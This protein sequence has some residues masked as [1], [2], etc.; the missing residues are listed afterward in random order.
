VHISDS[1]INVGD[2]C[3]TIKSGRDAEGR[4]INRPAESY[5]IT[6]C[7]MLRGH[8]GVVIGSEMSGSVKKI[9]ISNC[10]FDG[11]DRGIRLKSTRGRGGVVEDVRVSNVVMK[12]IREE[13]ITLNLYY[14]KAPPEP[15]SERTP[16][17]RR[18]H[19]SGISAEAEQAATLLGLPELP[20]E[21]VSFSDIDIRAKKGFV[22][23][24]TKNIR[25]RGVR[26]DTASGPSISAE[27][28]ENLALFDVGSN[29]PHAGTPVIALVDVKSSYVRGP[30]AGTGADVFLDVRGSSSE[31]ISVEG[32]LK[33]HK[34]G[35][36]AAKDLSPRAVILSRTATPEPLSLVAL[37]AN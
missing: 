37:P 10:I 24:D 28:S 6:N 2:D 3:I 13:A 33:I 18:I 15:V 19:M 29:S 5:T 26:I 31:A 17:F 36:V 16:R 34:T 12:N 8:G 4:R 23:T 35:V 20:L 14:T 1:H 9:T 22:I 32:D 21:D 30:L 27:R 25:L 11:T 7:T